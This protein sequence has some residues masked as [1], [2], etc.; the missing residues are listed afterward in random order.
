MHGWIRHVEKLW[1][2]LKSTFGQR[3]TVNAGQQSTQVNSQHRSTV[4]VGL[5]TWFGPT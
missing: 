2:G 5:L 1:E 4:N 3:S